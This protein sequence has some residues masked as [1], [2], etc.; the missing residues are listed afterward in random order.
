MTEILKTDPTG[1]TGREKAENRSG[2]KDE[3]S[4]NITEHT[5]GSFVLL[6]HPPLRLN[7][8]S[9]FLFEGLLLLK[10]RLG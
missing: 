2:Q 5:I 3:H 7:D 1:D 9:L 4:R 6:F 8:F 10:Q